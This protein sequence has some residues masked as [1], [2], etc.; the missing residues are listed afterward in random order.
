MKNESN[1]S[2]ENITCLST[3]HLKSVF[4]T[5]DYEISV[6]EKGKAS[7]AGWWVHQVR[8]QTPGLPGS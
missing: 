8:M 3:G 2:S 4:R 6:D 5:Q 7:I 1:S